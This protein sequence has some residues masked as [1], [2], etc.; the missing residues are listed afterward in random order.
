MFIH[1]YI[2]D[3]SRYFFL[4]IMIYELNLTKFHED[5]SGQNLLSGC[6]ITEIASCE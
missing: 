4:F 5:T 6:N 2:S 1:S 3:H